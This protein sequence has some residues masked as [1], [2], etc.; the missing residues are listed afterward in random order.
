MLRHERHQRARRRP[1]RDGHHVPARTAAHVSRPIPSRNENARC[2]AGVFMSCRPQ[3]RT[4]GTGPVSTGGYSGRHHPSKDVAVIRS[5]LPLVALLAAARPLRPA[6]CTASIPPTSTA[7][8]MPAP[9]SSTTPTARG[10]SRTRSP[11]TWIAGAAAGNPARSTRNTCATSSPSCR[12]A[13]TGP[14]AARASSPATSTPPAWTNPGSTRSAAS[15][16]SP[17]SPTSTRSRTRPACSA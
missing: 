17:G 3:G 9:T 4:S 12:R 16:S 15:R 1:R 5:S 7:T 14:R 11:T 2:E 10:G 13:P 6:R 8:A